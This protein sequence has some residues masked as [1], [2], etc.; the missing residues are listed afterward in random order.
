MYVAKF[1]VSYLVKLYL[2]KITLRLYQ[3]HTPIFTNHWLIFTKS[4]PDFNNITSWFSQ[5]HIPT[6]PKSHSDFA[7]STL[8]LYQDHWLIFTTSLADFHKITPDFTKITLRLGQITDWFSQKRGLI[9]KPQIVVLLYAVSKP[10][11]PPLCVLL[12]R[13]FQQF[14]HEPVG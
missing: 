11:P 6:L 10:H 3:N 9:L 12:V 4:L 5:N 1:M 14:R 8:R 13:R 2:F 7:K